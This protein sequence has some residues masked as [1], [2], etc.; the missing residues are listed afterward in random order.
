MGGGTCALYPNTHG[1]TPAS[2]QGLPVWGTR[3]P[4]QQG[5]RQAA[6]GAASGSG[7]RRGLPATKEPSGSTVFRCLLPPLP[8]PISAS[9]ATSCSGPIAA[10]GPHPTRPHTLPPPPRG[11]A[12][13]V[14]IPMNKLQFHS[15]KKRQ[16]CQNQML[17]LKRVN[18]DLK[19]RLLQGDMSTGPL[20]EVP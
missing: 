7:M 15:K 6:T 13:L 4:G 5:Q 16:W 8:P 18:S 20:F 1:N 9:E 3:Q 17:S 12:H 14:I 19:G 2:G 10:L 11:A